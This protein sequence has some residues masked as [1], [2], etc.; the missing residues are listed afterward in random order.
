MKHGHERTE[1][2]AKG[3]KWGQKIKS[4]PRLKR[5]VGPSSKRHFQF[6]RGCKP[7]SSDLFRAPYACKRWGGSNLIFITRWKKLR[8]KR[9]PSNGNSTDT[10]QWYKS[11]CMIQIIVVQ[12]CYVGFNEK[13]IHMV[14]RKLLV[15]VDWYALRS[16][17][18]SLQRF[19]A[20]ALAFAGLTAA[21]VMNMNKHSKRKI[22]P[23]TCHRSCRWKRHSQRSWRGY[24]ANIP[25]G[26]L[27]DDYGA[28]WHTYS[29]H[30]VSLEECSIDGWVCLSE[31]ITTHL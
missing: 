16:P 31:N 3:K 17:Y 4:E 23:R 14:M 11:E 21:A 6:H 29:V 19:S 5:R 13:W 10:Y 8:S 28:K 22:Y 7:G 30:D 27:C 24:P 2:Y 15:M 9:L 20:S 25:N 12:H 26:S 1:Q 18:V